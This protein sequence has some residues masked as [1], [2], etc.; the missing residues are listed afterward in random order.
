MQ[1]R[2]TVRSLLDP[3]GQRQHRQ[4][5]QL[6][7]AQRGIREADLRKELRSGG[8]IQSVL[9]V[10]RVVD[11][12]PEFVA[13][14]RVSWKLGYQILRVWRGAEERRFRTADAA[15]QLAWRSGFT[16]AVVVYRVGDPELNRF[17]GILAID[18][19]RGE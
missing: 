11:A 8:Q 10:A 19:G 18:G 6:A 15:L 4:D 9:V 5:A 17:R 3:A 14:L 13:Y 7:R 16:K 2:K 1:R 12:E